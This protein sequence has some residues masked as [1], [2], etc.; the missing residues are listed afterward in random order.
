MLQLH[1]VNKPKAGQDN[2]Q[3]ETQHGLEDVSYE[4]ALLTQAARKRT[5]AQATDDTDGPSK[6]ETELVEIKKT[7]TG[8][9]KGTNG[10][11]ETLDPE[12]KESQPLETEEESP[13]SEKEESPKPEKEERK[14]TLVESGIIYIFTRARVGVEDEPKGVQDTQR[15]HFVL[16]PIEQGTSIKDAVENDEGNCRLFALPKKVFPRTHNDRFMAFV[17]KGQVSIKDL[18]ETFFP[19]T[20]YETKTLGTRHTHPVTPVAEGVYSITKLDRSSYLTYILTIP[21][22][23][24][25]VQEELGLQPKGSFLLSVK[26]PESSSPAQARLPEKANYPKE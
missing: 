18:K 16:R 21:E 20:E 3:R 6:A 7:S 14:S 24:D 19:G 22:K 23:I 10:K 13:K 4:G 12:N 26:N 1:K 8:K 5:R 25:E 2:L 11:S 9:E 17:E 15:T